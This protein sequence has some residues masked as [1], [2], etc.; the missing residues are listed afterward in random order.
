[1]SCL[2]Q[3]TSFS[4]PNNKHQIPK[5]KWFDTLT[6]LSPVEGQI[7]MTHPPKADQTKQWAIFNAICMITGL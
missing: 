1:M 7:P 6:T 2:Y 5:P 4:N 3:F